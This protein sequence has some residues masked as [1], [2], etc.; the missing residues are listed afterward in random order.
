MPNQ[1]KK[2]FFVFFLCVFTIKLFA[3]PELPSFLRQSKIDSL[4]Q[5]KS[6]NND[7]TQLELLVLY[8][9]AWIEK[10]PDSI[11]IFKKLALLN[12]ELEQPNDA[13]IF[14]EKYINNTLDFTVLDDKSFDS[15]NGTEE[16]EILERKYMFKFNFLMF[17]YIYVALIGFFFAIIINFNKKANKY[18]K[19]FIGCFVFAHSLFILEFVLYISNYRLRLPHTYLM[20]SIFALLYGPLLYFYFKSVIKSHQFRKIDLL[21]FLPTLGLILFLY[22]IYSLPYSDK[23]EIILKINTEFINHVR[24]IFIAKI[25]SL[26]VYASLI[27]KML[28]NQKVENNFLIKNPSINKWM[29]T[30][31][32]IHVAYVVAYIVYSVAVNFEIGDF[33]RFIYYTQVGIM[34]LMV[35]YIAYM[36]Y[37]QPNVFNNEYVLSRDG[38]FFEKYKKSGLTEAL[39]SELRENLVKLLVE[40]KI[41]KE[42]NIS[43]EILSNKLNTTRHNTSQIINEHFDMNF[44]ELIN[45]F[46]IKEAVKMLQEDTHGSLNIIDIA[47][48]VGYNNKVTFNKAFKKETSVTP[49]EFINSQLK[50]T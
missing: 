10:H 36:A 35:I 18:S 16:Y 9:N 2:Y 40:D 4:I 24:M 23:T 22:P 29:N 34:S 19:I 8:H 17:L 21:H 14:T 6:I 48:E 50:N 3:I 15:I 47:Y 39:S 43:L 46:R 25:I 42:S 38:L 5:E 45:K 13:Y 41:Y 1:S 31:F 27:G 20:S 28:L 44:F 33:S 26:I 11:N 7:M 49:S 32:K 30:L 12:A 37:V